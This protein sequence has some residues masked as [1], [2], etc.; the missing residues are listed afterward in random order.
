MTE[1]VRFFANYAFSQMKVRK[2][3]ISAQAENIGSRKIAEKIGAKLDGLFR[4][5]KSRK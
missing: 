2:I 4:E 5:H 1:I 3:I